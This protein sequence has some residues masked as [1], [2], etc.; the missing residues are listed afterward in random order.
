MNEE[1]ESP[2]QDKQTNPDAI[3]PRGCWIALAVVGT[4]MLILFL[5]SALIVLMALLMIVNEPP[6]IHDPSLLCQVVVLTL[7]TPDAGG[8]L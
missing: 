5:M 6:Y 1:N 4:F 3:L 7:G 2:E 8:M